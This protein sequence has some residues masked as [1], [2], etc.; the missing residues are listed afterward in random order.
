MPAAYLIPAYQAAASVG[1][2]ISGLRQLDPQAAIL[3]VDDGSTDHTAEVAR[4]AGAS[5]ESHSRNLG[6]GAALLTGLR[7]LQAREFTTA[8]SVDADGQHRPEDAFRLAHHAAPSYSLVLGV[9]DLKRDGAALPSR[10]SNA[11]SNLWVS[12]FS[13][14][15]LGDTQCGLRRYPVAETLALGARARRFDFESEVI[16][17]AARRRMPIVEIPVSAIY[18][19]GDERVSHFHVV[20][21]PARIVLRLVQTA[22]TV[23]RAP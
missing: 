7:W 11:F 2:L 15:R 6:K 21:D 16:V 1:T 10:F 23:R 20:A 5:V 18:P 22:A 13:G 14:Q 8:T 17:R 12:C 4:S 19:P 3:V 9:R